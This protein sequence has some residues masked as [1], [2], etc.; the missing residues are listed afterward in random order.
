MA[1][2]PIED[3]SEDEAD[4]PAP[5]P[6]KAPRKS[7]D[8]LSGNQLIPGAYSRAPS[9]LKE[10]GCK[11]YDYSLHVLAILTTLWH[12]DKENLEAMEQRLKKAQK[13]FE[14]ATRHFHKQ[15]KAAAQQTA[16]DDGLE[17]E[18]PQSEPDIDA[19]TFQSSSIRPL[20]PLPLECPRPISILKKT[21]QNAH[22]PV[23]TSSR[24]FLN[25]PE[26]PA[27]GDVSDDSDSDS[28]TPSTIHP[29]SEGA[30]PSDMDVDAPEAGAERDS[31][32]H[33]T[34]PPAASR[35][36]TSDNTSSPPPLA[37]RH[38]HEPQFTDTYKAGSKGKPKAADYE[39]VVQA[40]LLRAM[41]E[42]SARVIILNAFPDIGLQTTW[43]KECFKN[44]SRA[45]NEHYKINGRMISLI[46]KRG[47]HIRS[48]LVTIVRTL[49]AKH[50]DFS[51]T[52]TSSAAIKFNRDLSDKLNKGAAFHYKTVDDLSGYA[53]NAIF[54]D[55][56]GA[57]LFKNKTSL[58]AL[59]PSKFNPYPLPALALEFLCIDHCNSEW[60]TG[61]HVVAEFKEKDLIKKYTT[62]LADIT[63][64]AELNKAVVDN[65][66]LKWYTRASRTLSGLAPD[67][68]TNIDETRAG[69]LRE[70]LEGHTGLTDSEAE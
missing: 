29:S 44:A 33:G 58:A 42:Y 7:R 28:P 63:T 47:S 49:F 17:S 66:C 43:A 69:A 10:A 38:R 61:K 57:V 4:A 15:N 34:T 26:D 50:Y 2:P 20:A 24:A 52:S 59:F 21:K 48:Q 25:L 9:A 45:A 23:K 53:G 56:R 18:E 65:L 14:K 12:S 46:K 41:Q 36:R 27:H 16:N 11:W 55:I 22:A 54:S 30:M 70:E 37:K 3:S 60:S 68:V 5:P 6:P 67:I 32:T 31:H 1:P 64:W 8:D 40:L 62:H 51:R 39:A 35:K 13:D 19:I